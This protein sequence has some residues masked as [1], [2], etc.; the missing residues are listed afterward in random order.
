M[1]VGTKS[2]LFG[3]HQFLLHPFFVFIAWYKLYGRMPTLK[4]SICIF[5][6][7]IGY[8]GKPNMD[9]AEGERHPLLGGHIVETI[10]GKR[11]G[12]IT[13]FHSRAYAKIM[14]SP[15]SILCIPDKLSILLYPK[16]LYLFLGS[17]S[18]EII[19]YKSRMGM[20]AMNNNQWLIEVRSMAYLWSYENCPDAYKEQVYYMFCD[21]DVKY[22]SPIE[23]L[24]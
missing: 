21:K 7:D 5:F 9:G 11:Y 8:F 13:M 24:K 10:I 12:E 19:E 15:V 16:W 22:A 18:G 1:K 14:N 17:I 4:E 3:V 20:E 23:G 2:V 6:H